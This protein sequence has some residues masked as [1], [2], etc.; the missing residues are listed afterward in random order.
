MRKNDKREVESKLQVELERLRGLT[1]LGLELR[2]IWSPT[3]VSHLSGKVED[4]I[5]YI[6][7]ADSRMALD[8]LRHEYFD[9]LVSV[10]IRPYEKAASLYRAMVNALVEKLGEEA[11]LEKERVVGAIMKAIESPDL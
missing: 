10:A 6:Y 7:E 8:V 2:V 9:Y 11:Y 3:D 1:G 5:I 4:D